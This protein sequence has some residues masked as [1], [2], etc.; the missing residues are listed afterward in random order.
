MHTKFRFSKATRALIVAATA[1]AISGVPQTALACTQVYVG[2]QLTA[3]GDTFWGRSEDYAN[4]YPKAFGV[5]PATKGGKTIQS[6]END[7][8]PKASF[9][10][11]IDGP[12]F[13]YTFVRDTPDNW[14][15]DG[16]AN[17]KAYSEA[18]TNEKGVSVSSTLT[19]SMNEK[20]DKTD[21]RVDTGIGEYSILDFVLSQASTAREG[22]ELLGKVIDEQGSQDCNQIVIGDATETWIFSQLSGTQWIAIKMAADEASVNPNMDDL[23]FDVDLDDSKNCLHSADIKKMA[24]KAGTYV[25]KD[26]KMDVAG[27]YGSSSEDQGVSQNTRYVQ[28][29]L[30]F[31]EQLKEG[32]DYTVDKDGAVA[33]VANP[34]LYVA[35]PAEKVDTFWVLRT[36]GARGEGTAVDAN[37]N[38]KLYAIG[39]NRNT[40]NHIFQ[41]RDGLDADIATIQWEGLSRSEFTL[42]IPSYSALLTEV[43]EDIYPKEANFDTSHVGDIMEY[44]KDE[45]GNKVYDP[46]IS[47][48]NEK[49]AMKDSGTSYL[50]YDL[51]DLNTLAY[52]H[53]AEVADGVHAYLDALQKDI[54][55]QHESVDTQMKDVA[56]G[57]ARMAFANKAHAV[58]SEQAGAKVHSLLQEVREYLEAGDSSKPFA[59]S[60]LA[61]GKLAAGLT[62]ADELAKFD[63]EAAAKDVVEPY[64]EETQ[65][66]QAPAEG[67]EAGS[68]EQTP[69]ANSLPSGV[70][71]I[72]IAAVVAIAGVVI[73]RG[74]KKE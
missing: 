52:N 12:T 70:I 4:R 72:I 54:I 64:E 63:A 21:P 16:D 22:V 47:K 26:G 15:E 32:S 9:S 49:I 45:D 60:D 58:V 20:M 8:D 11:K 5:A 50:D 48:S 23:K 56:A 36:L 62:Y 34:S 3:S 46:A 24:E 61:D 25:E 14:T 44:S 17:A 33:T 66:T 73:Y 57:K 53:R 28:G 30:Y 27:S 51:M 2:S 31:G 38:D 39:N 37:K 13:R 68:A 74:R 29:H 7:T 67:S 55:A 35:A 59:A 1:V 10:Y 71:G 19:T 18:G 40:E 6:Y 69:A 65:E 43:N 41:V 42:F